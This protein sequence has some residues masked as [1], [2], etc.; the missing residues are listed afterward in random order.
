MSE[1]KGWGGTVLGWFVVKEGEAP[2]EGLPDAPAESAAEL[3]PEPPP[4]EPVTPLPSAVGGEVDFGKV[5]EAFGVTVEERD[6]FEKAATLLTSLPPGTDAAVQKQI[7]EASLKAFGIPI[8]KIIETGV[9]SIQAL[10]GYQRKGAADTAAFSQEVGSLIAGY[11]EKI[12]EVRSLL[13]QRLAESAKVA[14]RCN[15]RKLSVQRVL[16]FFG[17]EAVARVVRDS[18]RLVD[19]SAPPPSKP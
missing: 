7:V 3:P 8:E 13:E 14:A 11:E 1:K 4:P 19:P 16:E 15:E 6:R 18:P 2:A 5:Y 17:Q 9:E 10:E 12:R